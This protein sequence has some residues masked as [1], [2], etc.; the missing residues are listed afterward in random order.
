M[1]NV[2]Y[3]YH[4]IAICIFFLLASHFSIIMAQTENLSMTMEQASQLAKM[5]LSC[6]N[7]EY[8]NK[9]GQVIGDH[10]DLKAPRELHP[11]FY[12]CFD[13]HSSVHGHWMLIRLLKMFP[14][15]PENS[16]IRDHIGQN[17]TAEN[18]AREVEYFQGHLNKTYERT[19]GWAWLLKLAA[20]LNSWEDPLGK[21]WYNN[22]QPLTLMIREKFVEFLPKLTYPIRTGEHP[23]TAFGISLAIDYA[24]TLND[25]EFLEL[26]SA[27]SKDYYLNDAA[28]PLDWEPNGFD[29]LSPCLEEA[30]LMSKVLD[31][32]DYEKWLLS[33]FPALKSRQFILEPAMVSDRSDPKIVHLDG[34]N[35]SRSW[36]LSGI[37]SKYDGPESETIKTLVKEHFDASYP[38]IA[39][40]NYEGEHW[41]ASFAVL[42]LTSA[43]SR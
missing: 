2:E 39:S 29:F 31:K 35:L 11:A 9:L 34:L 28:C 26:L 6:I 7:K 14:E 33:F 30:K 27:R 16:A 8:P 4:F 20:E 40:G 42:A 21:T 22:L 19:Y 12:G 18:I 24:L 32:R 15:L 25:H 23:N 38:Y 13:W 43:P 5:P 36:C 1:T 3:K 37:S 17:I 10:T 41:L